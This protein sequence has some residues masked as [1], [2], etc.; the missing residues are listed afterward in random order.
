MDKGAAIK[1]NKLQGK[2]LRIH[3]L[4]HGLR[5]LQSCV[6]SRYLFGYKV[7]CTNINLMN[8]KFPGITRHTC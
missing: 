5:H 1:P 4:S 3:A 2:R 7:G 6:Q 8:W